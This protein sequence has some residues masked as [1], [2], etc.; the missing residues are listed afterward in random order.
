MTAFDP[1]LWGIFVFGLI[2]GICP[3]N[4]QTAFQGLLTTFFYAVGLSIP[5]L[6]ISIAGGALGNKIK[7]LTAQGGELFDKVIGAGIILIG[8]YFT[9]R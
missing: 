7:Q 5:L 1:T 3:C 2:A 6:I 4:D 9:W 8:L